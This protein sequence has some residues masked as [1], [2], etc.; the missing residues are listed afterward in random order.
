MNGQPTLPMRKMRLLILTVL[1]SA[2]VPAILS[3]MQP[4]PQPRIL[5][6][7]KTAG[8]RHGSIPAG[9]A[10]IRKLGAENGFAVDTTE[11]AAYFHEDSLK[12]YSAVVF[13]NATGDV[14]NAYQQAD[15][16]RYIQAGGGYMGIH[17]AADCEYGW[18]WYGKLVGGYFKSHPKIQPAKLQV[19]DRSH[20]STKHL[21]EVWERSDEWYNFRKAPDAKD[22]TVL[23]RIDEKS[24]QGGENGGDHPMVWYHPFDGGRA[25]YTEFGHTDESYADPLYLKH[26]LG[27]I[28]YAI[29]DNRPLDYKKAHSMRVPDEDRFSKNMLVSGAFD[30]PTEM[31]VLPNLDIIVVQRKG[32]ILR[33][34]AKTKKIAEAGNLLVYHKTSVKGVNAEEGLMGIAADPNY[35]RNNWIYLFYAA[36]DTPMNRLSR[37]VFKD[38]QLDAS[39]EKKILELYSQR[40]ICCHTGGSLSFGGDGLL[41]LSTGDN[42][43][44]FNQ[45]VGFKN[46]GFAPIDHRE[47]LQQ[48]DASRSSGNTN[49]LRGKI[50]RIRVKPDGSYEIPEGNLFKPGVP[51]ARPEIYVMGNRNPYRISVDRKTGFLYWGEVGPDA[52]ADSTATRGPRGYDELNQARKAGFFG[53]PFFVGNNYPYRAYNYTSG[54]VGAAFDPMR[55]LNL[56]PYNTGLKE[57]PPVSPAFIWYP[58]ATSPDFPEVGTGGRNAMAGPVYY[59]EFYPAATRFPDYFKGKLFFYDWIRGWIKIVTMDGQGNYQQMEPFMAGTKFNSVIDM[60]M[61]PDGRLYLLEYGT[62]WFTKNKDAGLARVD[63]NGGNRAPR[64]VVSVNRTSGTL[65]LTVKASAAGS[66]DSDKDALTYV[67]H[68][69]NMV[70]PATGKPDASFTFTKPGDYPVFVEVKDGKGGVTRSETTTVY[71][72]NEEPRV[73]IE[74]NPASSFYFAGKP[75][76]YKVSVTDKEDG[77]TEKGGI[78]EASLQVKVDYLSSPD[79]AQV[80]GH[81]AFSSLAE[82]RNLVSTLDC[83]TCHKENEKSIG[84]SYAMVAEKYVKDPKAKPY[85]TGKIIKGGGGVW[86]EVA[87]AAHPDLREGD[88]ALIVDWILSLAGGGKPAPGLPAKGSIAP[89]AKEVAESKLMLV[90]ASYTDKGAPKSRPLTGYTTLQF[91][92]PLLSVTDRTSS[93][94]I[95]WVDQG[96]AKAAVVQGDAG[97]LMFD[98]IGLGHVSAIELGYTLREPLVSGYVVEWVADAPDGRK[99]GEA[100]IGAGGTAGAGKVKA[101]LTGLVDR[102]VTL[103]LKVRKAD[104]RETKP[105][106]MQQIRFVSE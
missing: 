93:D 24:Y 95:Q 105:L 82:G 62:G 39:S 51:G 99:I 70:M 81:Q 76:S 63:Y 102:P 66:K 20:A 45:P 4:T 29:G 57:L 11:N 100:V 68:F 52:N 8:F 47:G 79:K 23:V 55:P 37:F 44:P 84:P 40:Q 69:G 97:W 106:V 75:L 80:L 5:V 92:Q 86:G 17:A 56:S 64:A 104:A 43:T 12:R 3:W 59:P 101:P 60:E 85:L 90:T 83:K 46:N 77:S 28:Q 91:K 74:T 96:R 22:V 103:Y 88:A 32:G 49:D 48:Y 61:G 34:D 35:A 94:R 9:I 25:Y 98:R 71:A 10:A 89:S 53:W 19:V 38:G 72:G 26:I 31:A 58:Y 2:S 67:W 30:E 42:S 54:E 14:L 36:P 33:Y 18:P 6:F 27:G 65:P 13:L 15:F 87:M 41:Y 50:L 78:D 73:S 7:S 21:P 1:V 16:E